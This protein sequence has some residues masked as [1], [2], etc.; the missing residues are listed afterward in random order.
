MTRPG[1]G[2]HRWTDAV[3]ERWRDESGSA[4]L[5][6]A[7]LGI[8]VIM[9]FL[10]VSF[11]WRYHHTVGAVNDAAAEAARAASLRNPADFAAAADSAAQESLASMSFL[12]GGRTVNAAGGSGSVTAT[13]TCDVPISDLTLLGIAGVITIEATETEVVDRYRGG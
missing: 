7:L 10:L 9:G 4:A 3:G 1:N 2:A 5:E 11:G 8:F 13:V 12:C 6:L